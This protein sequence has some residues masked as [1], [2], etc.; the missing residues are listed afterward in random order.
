MAS[1]PFKK[2]PVREKK[3]AAQKLGGY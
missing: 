3:K 2:Y 1:D